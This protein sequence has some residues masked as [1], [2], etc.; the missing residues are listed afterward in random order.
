MSRIDTSSQASDSHWLS[1]AEREQFLLELKA[2]GWAEVEDRDALYKEL[3]FKSFNQ[4]FG[5]MTRVA[6]QAEKLNH[7]P[8]WFNV[9]NKRSLFNG[10]IMTTILLNALFMALETDYDLKFRLF[11]FFEIVDQLFQAI[12]TMEFLMK[13]YVEWRGY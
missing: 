9:Y 12:Y 2:T 5:F 10:V 3:S 7:H 11:G 4:A 6:L 13:V 8:E 1:P